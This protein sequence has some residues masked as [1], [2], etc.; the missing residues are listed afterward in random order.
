M[1]NLD[2]IVPL[3][4]ETAHIWMVDLSFVDTRSVAYYD[5]LSEDERDRASRFKFVKDRNNYI[6]CRAVLRKLSAQYL[7]MKPQEICFEYT[8]FGKPRFALETAINFNVSH[9][10]DVAVIGFIENQTI[11]IDIELIKQDFDVLEIAHNFFSK[12]ELYALKRLPEYLNYLG[13]YRC[14]TRK[15]AFVKAEGSGLSFPLNSFAVSIDSDETASLLETNWDEKEKD[16]WTLYP[17]VPV[18]NYIAALAVKSKVIS[19]VVNKWQ[20]G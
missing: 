20:H 14:W 16:K 6:V 12:K 8:D 17:F 4:P 11:G 18:Q 7:K 19:A 2:D 10:G 5:L 15:E 1:A 13:F 9:S 3:S